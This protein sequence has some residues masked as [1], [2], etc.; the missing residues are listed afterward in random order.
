VEV[1]IPGSPPRC[2]SQSRR[3]SKETGRKYW[4]QTA[5][6][7]APLCPS[8]RVRSVRS[9]WKRTRGRD[10]WRMASVL[11]CK[12]SICDARSN[13]PELELGMMGQP[14]R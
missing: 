10:V 12:E 6:G 11:P 7:P 13:S 2:G 3:S 5:T 14:S 9:T 8:S 4:W 1:V